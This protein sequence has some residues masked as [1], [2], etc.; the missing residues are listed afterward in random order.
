MKLKK[1]LSLL[2]TLISILLTTQACNQ[3]DSNVTQSNGETTSQTN[4]NTTET[5]TPEPVDPL[6]KYDQKKSQKLTDTAKILAG[7]S[8]DDNSSLAEIQKTQAWLNNHNF[9]E[10][11]WANLEEKQYSKVRSWSATE[12]K[13]FHDKKTPVFYP[14]SGAD[15]LYLYKLFP[16]AE[17]YIMF[18]L[19]PVG[20]IPDFDGLS[21]EQTNQKLVDAR[22]SLDAILAWSFFRTLDMDVDLADQG[23]LPIIFLFMARTNNKILDIQYISLEPDATIKVIDE[24]TKKEVEEKRKNICRENGIKLDACTNSEAVVKAD[25]VVLGV[26]IDFLPE[27]E[28]NPRTLYYFSGNLDNNGMQG[29]PQVNEFVKQFIPNNM[30]TYLKAASYLMYLDVFTDIRD[31]ILNNSTYVLQDDSGMPLKSFDPAK[32]DFQLYG[33]YTAPINLFSGNTQPDLRQ[34]YQSDK[35]V[36]PLNFG[37]GYQYQVGTS[38]LMLTTKKEQ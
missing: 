7:M 16:Q 27:R 28:T 6:A 23:V 12:L 32:W 18:A 17:K 38:N 2:I 14:F 1:N 20:K 25:N 30:I 3:T 13:Q 8:L 5:S 24:A 9:F 19:D 22:T 36:K 34:K 31:S 15:F 33:T 26:Q 11:E 10:S 4:G 21:P 35:N 37:I 29:R